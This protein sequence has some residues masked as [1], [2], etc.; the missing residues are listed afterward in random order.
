MNIKTK[1]HFVN[2]FQTSFVG[3]NKI[4]RK[5]IAI[6]VSTFLVAIFGVMQ[7]MESKSATAT[8]QVNL[9]VSVAQAL[10]LGC[11]SDVNFGTLTPGVAVTGTT[12]CQT[13]T[14]A[15]GYT[16]NVKRD[17]SDTTLDLDSDA[18]KNIADKTAWNSATPNGATWSGTGLGFRVKQ[19]G[20]NSGYSTTWWGADD[21]AGNAKY[22]GLPSA[23]DKILEYGSYSASATD[24][25]I[26]YKLDVPASQPSGAYS[27]SVTFQAVGNP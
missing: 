17:D 25:V 3:F 24:T 7:A 27:G 16:L 19:T 9:S 4:K 21:T 26:E 5:K 10:T 13:T 2:F 18:T 8:D 15:V 23:Y 11:G 1:F 14:N 6:I 22:A 12:T 20:T